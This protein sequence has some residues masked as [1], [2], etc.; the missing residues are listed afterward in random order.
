MQPEKRVGL[1]FLGKLVVF[2]F[3]LACVAGGV[4]LL[5]G[6]HPL[7][8]S[9]AALRRYVG[10]GPAETAPPARMSGAPG[11]YAFR[12][13]GSSTIAKVMGKLAEA[14]RAGGG[15]AVEVVSESTGKGFEALRTGE[16][17]LAM[18]SRPIKPEEEAAMGGAMT[19][20]TREHVIG[21]DAVA[22]VVNARNPLRKLTVGTFR[23][24]LSGV[25][26]RWEKVPGSEYQGEIH[27]YGYNDTSG[28]QEIVKSA[29]LRGTAPLPPR[30]T[31]A[32]G[33]EESALVESDPLGIG[34]VSMAFTSRNRAVA[35]ADGADLPHFYPNRFTVA[36]ES[37]PV[38]R[39]LLLY[40]SPGPSRPEVTAFLDFVKGEQAQAIIGQTFVP[41]TLA[42]S[43]E[44][45]YREADEGPIARLH[46]G[47]SR[48]STDFRFRSGSSRLDTKAHG[49][50]GRI[51]GLIE[52]NPGKRL[53]L[54]GFADSIGG[55]EAN[56][57]LS[58]ERARVV[59]D[60]LIMNGLK[61][62]AVDGFG[63]AHPVADNATPE[64]RER[65]R[66]VEIW[67]K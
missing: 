63:T 61:V 6:K 59:A 3:I 15:P 40:S 5:S 34:Y 22:V 17:P 14:Y 7:D 57:R 47:A 60:E 28:I 41:L 8:A 44:L 58:R 55:A 62:E 51:V 38:T 2:L 10:H 48:L 37:Y 43:S 27:V 49:D 64:G 39:R 4:Y 21:I 11:P 13:K 23:D 67:I 32:N 12:I 33:D 29:V 50:I 24:I 54:F 1:T 35:L 19:D 46:P 18:A 20:P 53:L 16:V 26:D 9:V 66:R 25:V 31:A 45:G 65:N 42:A 36:T 52:R 30:K 56:L